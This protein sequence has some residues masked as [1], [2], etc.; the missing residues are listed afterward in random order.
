MKII[1]TTKRGN[2]KVFGNREYKNVWP[3]VDKNIDKK[4]PTYNISSNCTQLCEKKEFFF[5]MIKYKN[6]QS[7]MSNVNILFKFL[8]TIGS[9]SHLLLTRFVKSG[10]T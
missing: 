1:W 7:V 4:D 2:N 6:I 8:S 9:A 5:S 3:T 10:R